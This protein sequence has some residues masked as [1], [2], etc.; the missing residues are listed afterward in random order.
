MYGTVYAR[1]GVA[2]DG[3]TIAHWSTCPT[4]LPNTSLP[5]ISSRQLQR[6]S[7][8]APDTSSDFKEPTRLVVAVKRHQSF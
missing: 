3:T 7:R 2:D 6:L 1:C 4:A 8:E 5:Y